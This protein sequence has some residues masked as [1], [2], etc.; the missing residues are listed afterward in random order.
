MLNDNEIDTLKENYDNTFTIDQ[1]TFENAQVIL[2]YDS[3]IEDIN[4]NEN[5]NLS[6]YSKSTLTMPDEIE[7]DIEIEDTSIKS[8]SLMPCSVVDIIDSKI[9]CCNSSK[10]LRGLRQMV[11]T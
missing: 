3:E 8:L 2:N 11:G 10:N 9:K 1:V 7:I 4:W 6:I 5:E